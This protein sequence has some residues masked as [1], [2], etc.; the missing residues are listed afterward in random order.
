MFHLEVQ[1]LTVSELINN[2]QYQVPSWEELDSMAVTLFDTFNENRRPDSP[3]GTMFGKG[4]DPD[5]PIEKGKAVERLVM[6][7][8]TPKDAM[9][10]GNCQWYWPLLRLSGNSC[11]VEYNII[12]SIYQHLFLSR[13]EEQ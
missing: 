7:I 4:I 5:D 11:V 8:E 6:G 2:L 1:S 13:G 12:L 10:Y 9:I 3:F